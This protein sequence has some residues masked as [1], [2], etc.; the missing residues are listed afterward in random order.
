MASIGGLDASL[1][2]A[3]STALLNTVNVSPTGEQLDLPRIFL[4]H[5]SSQPS[6]ATHSNSNAVH[7]GG[8][9]NVVRRLI[10][11]VTTIATLLI[12]IAILLITIVSLILPLHPHP[13]SLQPYSSPLQA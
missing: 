7:A 3:A 10:D 2:K 1:S 5:I 11:A 4:L 13:A 12:T 6:S 8:L 9:Q